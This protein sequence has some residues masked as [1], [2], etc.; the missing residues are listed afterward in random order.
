MKRKLTITITV[1]MFMATMIL[2]TITAE[3]QTSGSQQIRARIPF[4]FN[5]GKAQLPAG[6][7][8][9]AVLNPNS[10]RKVLQIRSAD[11]KLSALIQTSELSANAPERTKLV[12]NRYGDRYFFAQAQM[13][14]ESTKLAAAKSSAERNEAQAVARNG[15]KATLAILAE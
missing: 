12:F 3:A 10:D 5:V 15:R 4:A 2:A 1:L 13:A 7:Y 14:G 11:G 8:T 9:V 6:E